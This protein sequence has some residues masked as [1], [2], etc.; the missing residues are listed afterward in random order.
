MPFVKV[1]HI[2]LYPFKGNR[3]VSPRIF[4]FMRIRRL[5]FQR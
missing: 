3:Q 2:R 4:I 5:L 1:Y